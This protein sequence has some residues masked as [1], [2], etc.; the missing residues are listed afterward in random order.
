M[1]STSEFPLA[2]SQSL[3]RL[4]QSMKASDGAGI[5]FIG[6][7]EPDNEI[8]GSDESDTAFLSSDES[9]NTSD[10]EEKLHQDIRLILQE[11][12]GNVSKKW[13]NSE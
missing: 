5:D 9:A 12:S 2:D 4:A 13:G 3:L 6:A 10:G 7:D 11:N 1:D 8:L